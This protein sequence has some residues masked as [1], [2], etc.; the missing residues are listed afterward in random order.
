M[1]HFSDEETGAQRH[2]H[3]NQPSWTTRNKRLT[4]EVLVQVDDFLESQFRLVH[5]EAED[6]GA[7]VPSLQG[8]AH[9]A[10]HVVG[11]SAEVDAGLGVWQ[12]VV[13]FKPGHGD[14]LCVES[15]G[16]VLQLD[17]CARLRSMKRA[18]QGVRVAAPACKETPPL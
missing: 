8:D 10:A 11:V 4:A 15:G 3:P 9:T 5:D 7:H 14:V 16:H 12:R 13:V 2:P 6:L 1:G 17:A 18:L